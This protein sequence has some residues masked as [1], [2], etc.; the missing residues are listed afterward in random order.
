MLDALA[1]SPARIFCIITATTYRLSFSGGAK[2]ESIF[3]IG[4][5]HPNPGFRRGDGFL[6]NYHVLF[7]YFPA[8][9]SRWK[10]FEIFSRKRYR[11]RGTAFSNLSF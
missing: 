4:Y 8:E 6:R 7:K 5:K 1:K 10:L 11:K 9:N 3:L 2:P